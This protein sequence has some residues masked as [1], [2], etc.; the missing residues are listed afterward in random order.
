[1]SELKSKIEEYVKNDRIIL[2]F[3]INSAWGTGKTYSVNK[4]QNEVK[5]S[6]HRYE[7]INISVNGLTERDIDGVV[8]SAIV[9]SL[10][11][12]IKKI[13]K[14][15][16]KGFGKLLNMVEYNGFKLDISSSFLSTQPNMMKLQAQLEN[17][18]TKPIFVFDDVER[19][20]D[21][22]ALA[23][24]FGVIATTLQEQL[25]AH[26]IIIVNESELNTGEKEFFLKNREK[27]VAQVTTL[28]TEKNSAVDSILNELSGDTTEDIITSIRNKIIDINGTN[29]INLRT[30]TVFASLFNTIWEDL[31]KHL[32]TNN[33]TRTQIHDV[34]K[35]LAVLMYSEV[36]Q[37]REPLHNDVD[38]DVDPEG[39]SLPT[40]RDQS[41]NLMYISNMDA[42][43]LI[44]FITQGLPIESSNLATQISRKFTILENNEFLEKI[45]H[46]RDNPSE[47]LKQAQQQI[48]TSEDLSTMFDSV[49][50]VCNMY[51]TIVFFK[52]NDL[53]LL[54]QEKYIKLLSMLKHLLSTY[55]LDDLQKE[56]QLLSMFSSGKEVIS[57]LEE[58]IAN[59]MKDSNLLIETTENIMSGDHNSVIELFHNSDMEWRNE[60][61]RMLIGNLTDKSKSF[62]QKKS[63]IIGLSQNYVSLSELDKQQYKDALDTI[64]TTPGD[65]VLRRIAKETNTR[66]PSDKE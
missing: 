58:I 52:Q 37:N 26:V 29:V 44:D 31:A 17:D 51:S 11:K 18:K 49:S 35:E 55:S 22:S 53:W 33:L 46:F 56:K 15:A 34:Y 48:S 12:P 8:Q 45:I 50:D 66:L 38:S 61:T 6:T 42:Y 21:K 14:N 1:M 2:G 47:S 23:K 5:S 28:G 39:K 40:N 3:E 60:I 57:T 9:A 27:I 30:L 43:K 20:Q 32:K 16:G 13:L 4:I 25:K 54:N 7:W 41:L 64:T 19:I 24:L 65:A 36:R 63:I 62:Y 59:K 10:V